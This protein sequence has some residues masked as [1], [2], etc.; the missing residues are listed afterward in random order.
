MRRRFLGFGLTLALAALG[1][2]TLTAQTYDL[3][4]AKG[5]VID[6]ESGLD[7]I[8]WIGIN[9]HTIAAISSAPLAGRQVDGAAPGLPTRR[10]PPQP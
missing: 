9:G 4:L 5:R 8:R 10:P 1:P 3:V 2:A 6:P 7:A